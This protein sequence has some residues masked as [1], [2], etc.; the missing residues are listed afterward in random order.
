MKDKNKFNLFSLRSH[1]VHRKQRGQSLIEFVL[2][3][4]VFF[5]FFFIFLRFALS[6]G[7]GVYV[8][9]AVF[10]AARAYFA[11][12]AD[13]RDQQQRGK[14][15]LES[16]LGE[17][18]TRLRSLGEPVDE[19]IMVGAASNFSDRDPNLRWLQGASFGF[20][21]RMFYQPLIP[22]GSL[23]NPQLD[24]VSE[25]FLGREP[26]SQE[27]RSAMGDWLYDNGC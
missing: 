2:V 3:N 1:S 21:F 7:Y 13:Q 19:R 26:T 10:M 17:G 11:A 22:L 12:S 25:T 9:H 23:P 24:L 14:A 5:T 15:V 27:C 18:G 4:F 16:Y 20:K 6:L 8:Q